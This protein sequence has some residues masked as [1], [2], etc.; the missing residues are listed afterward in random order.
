MILYILKQKKYYGF[1]YLIIKLEKNQTFL[2]VVASSDTPV[3]I[4]K[5]AYC[6][7]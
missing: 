4:V 2:L 7:K 5:N 6:M 1:K 3:H